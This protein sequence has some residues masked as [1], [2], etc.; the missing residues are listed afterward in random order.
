MVCFESKSQVW[1]VQG[2]VHRRFMV[3][4]MRWVVKILI[5]LTLTL[6]SI[7]PLVVMGTGFLVKI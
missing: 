2:V 5:I 6:K 4:L 3:S 1:Q 7:L